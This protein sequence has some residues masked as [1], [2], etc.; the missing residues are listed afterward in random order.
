MELTERDL[1][2]GEL[3]KDSCCGWCISEGGA[4][5]SEYQRR[6]RSQAT[7]R[8]I[9]YESAKAADLATMNGERKS[10]L[11]EPDGYRRLYR[12]FL[13]EGGSI[14]RSTIHNFLCERFSD[15][16]TVDLALVS[17]PDPIW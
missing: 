4:E 14:S 15:Q 6:Q 10:S 9:R 5:V 13:P 3:P 8:Q 1:L 17:G 2:H 12:F 11:P 16:I 7:F